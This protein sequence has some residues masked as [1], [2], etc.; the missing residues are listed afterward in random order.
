MQCHFFY[1]SKQPNSFEQNLTIFFKLEVFL[2]FS[3]SQSPGS[4]SKVEVNAPFLAIGKLS[5]NQT[6]CRQDQIKKLTSYIKY[7]SLCEHLEVLLNVFITLFATNYLVYGSQLI[8]SWVEILHACALC[9]LSSKIV[10]H[11]FYLKNKN[12]IH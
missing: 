8:F 6:S 4:Q 2:I 7:T 12:K 5:G 3:K 1:K 11:S 9:L 10:F